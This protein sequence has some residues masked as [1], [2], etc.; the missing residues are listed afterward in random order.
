MVIHVLND[1]IVDVD[2]NIGYAK[3]VVECVMGILGFI[4]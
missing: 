1:Q 2:T 3:A 4:C